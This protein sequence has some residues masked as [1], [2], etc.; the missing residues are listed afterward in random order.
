MAGAVSMRSSL[1]FRCSS[2][3]SPAVSLQLPRPQRACVAVRPLVV[4][5]LASR[6]CDMT[7]KR[8]NNGYKISFSHHKTKKV[9]QVNLQR[10]KL[11][12][13]ERKR[14]VKMR[15]STKALKTIDRKG[16]Q[17]VAKDNGINLNK[18]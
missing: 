9:Q 6:V 13:E 14:F 16:L 1:S 12:W 11:W 18:F 2:F 4:R 5:P 15:I 17:Q 10:K 3:V 7:G 8:R